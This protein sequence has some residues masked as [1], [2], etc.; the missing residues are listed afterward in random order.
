[1][2]ARVLFS[3]PKTD[4]DAYRDVL[5][6]ALSDLDVDADIEHSLQPERPETVD[7]IVYAP[8][9]KL[10]DFAPFTG[11]KAVLNLWAGV[12]SVVHNQTLTQPLARM[13][14]PGLTEGM[15]EW[16]TGHVLRH[17]L[18]LD[19]DIKRV[20][21]EWVPYVPPLARDRKVVIL[22]LGALGQAV[23]QALAALNF[24]VIGWSRT[25]KSIPGLTCFS[26]DDGLD[27]ALICAEI[28]VLLLPLTPATEN[29]MTS[30]RI[31]AMPKG[32]VLINPGRG[33]LVDDNALIAALDRG[34]LAH[35][36][37]DV[38][39]EEPLPTGHPFWA[40]PKVTVT[41]HIASATRPE[42]AAR[43]IAENIRRGE[44]GEPFL[45]LV[46]RD[47]GY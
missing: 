29:V 28:L 41:P 43:V 31:D 10:Q 5:A 8:S 16:C 13:V 19:R 33:P 2:R 20:D 14:D 45:H 27:K 40:H 15:V 6:T 23:G 7:Y 22:G 42:S 39:R 26:G 11:A 37:L 36:T 18:D 3:A 44:A 9:S 21:H 1:M 12:E 4:W 24:D 35:A 30:V 32:A 25:D 17:H 34:H 46:D 38:F 47:L